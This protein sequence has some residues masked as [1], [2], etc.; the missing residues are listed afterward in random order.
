L[1]EI[2]LQ[3]DNKAWLLRNHAQNKKFR[4]VSVRAA[5]QSEICWMRR[6]KLRGNAVQ[7]IVVLS[8]GTMEARKSNTELLILLVLSISSSEYISLD[9]QLLSDI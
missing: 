3:A 7:I 6:T 4:Q 1:L 5:N 2:L 8:S 9:I